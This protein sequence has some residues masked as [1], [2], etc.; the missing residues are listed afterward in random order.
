MYACLIASLI[1][2]P[3]ATFA[4]AQAGSTQALQQEI[5]Q[6]KRDFEARLSALEAKMAALGNPPAAAQGA[7][8][9]QQPPQPSEQVPAGAAGAGGPS[10]QLP[11]YGGASIGDSGHRK[12]YFGLGRV[13]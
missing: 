10:G 7:E 5:D 3:S 8:Q 6:L 13:F 9:A 11:V 2:A 4:Q 12:W 1:G